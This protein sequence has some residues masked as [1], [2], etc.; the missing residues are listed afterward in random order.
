MTFLSGYGVNP[1]GWPVETTTTSDL[2]GR[3]VVVAL[4]STD[5]HGFI[6]IMRRLIAVLKNL[7]ITFSLVFSSSF[8]GWSM[9]TPS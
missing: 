5:K 8:H 6:L 3:G 9:V 2:L 1:V 7:K 4:L